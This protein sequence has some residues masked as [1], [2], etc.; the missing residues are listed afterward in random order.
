MLTKT[1]GT[2]I[3]RTEFRNKVLGCW[4]GKSIGGTLGT[5]WENNREMND[6]VFYPPD[7]N[8][9][10]LPNDDLD[11][12]LVWL[13]AVERF[14]VRNLDERR[15]A[16]FWSS[17]IT[18]PWNE[19]GVCRNNIRMGI[20]PPMSGRVGN[21]DWKWS[22]G[23]WI[24]S[25]I[26]AC[27]FPASP[28]RAVRLAWCDACCDHEGEGIY[29]ELFTA[30]LESAAFAENDLQKLLDIALA[31]IPADCRVAR[32][33]GLARACYSE[34]VPFAEA[35][36]R[37]VR[38]SEDIGWFQAPANLGFVVL[39]L[40]YGE[41][42]FG[43]TVALAVNCGDDTDCTAGTA[44]A[45]LGIIYGKSGIPEKWCAPIGDSIKTC[46]IEN[47]GRTC[48]MKVPATLTEL[49]DRVI[50]CA[51]LA[52]F[53]DPELPGFSDKTT[54]P[55]SSE[56]VSPEIMQNT[57][58]AL[59]HKKSNELI[60]DLPY[61]T[62]HFEFEDGSCIIEEGK[63]IRLKIHGFMNFSELDLLSITPALPAGW[64]A[65]PA[66]FSPFHSTVSMT[67]VPGANI[68]PL[69]LL[70]LSVTRNGFLCPDII[71][72]PLVKKERLVLNTSHWNEEGNYILWEEIR[73]HKNLL[74]KLA[75][76]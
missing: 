8:G 73:R 42:D 38:D 40:L 27:L 17:Y 52:A 37:I 44:G 72:L 76:K 49:T 25:E 5:P 51:E 20:M 67:V 47:V 60:Y 65:A 1:A 26:W 33:T 15:L 19:Y 53:E 21:E 58:D 46:S 68:E 61:G 9:E 13:A 55:A 59:G 6:I 23:A 30:A 69:T 63:P 34:R 10:P 12:Q 3:S 75:E 7:I 70:P 71:H 4:Y 35:R 16:Q 11:L 24:R 45:I 18:G 39:A 57:R 28:H 66:I 29:A 36:N 50:C 43:R 2:T 56:L 62:L 54:L 48:V 32:A 31:F 14:G 64:Q 22:N 74:E 41:G